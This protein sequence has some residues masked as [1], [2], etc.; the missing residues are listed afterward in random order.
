MNYKNVGHRIRWPTLPS[1]AVS[2]LILVLILIA[3]LVI[4]LILVVVLILILV[5][6][7]Y[8]SQNVLTA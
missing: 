3:V 1:A 4:V 8:S 5:I 2:A 6:H 7:A